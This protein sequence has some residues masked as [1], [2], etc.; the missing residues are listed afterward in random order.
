MSSYLGIKLKV[1]SQTNY[2][3]KNVVILHFNYLPRLLIVQINLINFETEFG[4]YINSVQNH[5]VYS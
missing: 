2:C 3:L 4:H 1:T 5:G